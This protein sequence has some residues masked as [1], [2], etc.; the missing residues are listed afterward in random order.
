[1]QIPYLE[2]IL[3][4]EMQVATL[5]P[6]YRCFFSASGMLLEEFQKRPDTFRRDD[7]DE[8]F[9]LRHLIQ[10]ERKRKIDTD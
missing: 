6:L 5:S 10:Q 2:E 7:L 3:N 9:R 4:Q 8:V 1:M